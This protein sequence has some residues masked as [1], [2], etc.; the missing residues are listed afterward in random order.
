MLFVI[1]KK[2]IQWCSTRFRICGGLNYATNLILGEAS[3]MV[4]SIEWRIN[5]KT[6]AVKGEKKNGKGKAEGWMWGKKMKRKIIYLWFIK[7]RVLGEIFW[8]N[9]G[10]L[11]SLSSKK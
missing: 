3:R 11:G 10:L 2:L 5:I 7:F 1:K 6:V 4:Q 9:V 8:N